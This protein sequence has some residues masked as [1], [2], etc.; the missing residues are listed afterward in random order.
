M[1]RKDPARQRSKTK[2]MDAKN[3]AN[4]NTPAIKSKKKR[5]RS[6]RKPRIIIDASSLDKNNTKSQLKGEP[7]NSSAK[8]KNMSGTLLTKRVSGDEK[9][10]LK[11]VKSQHIS[12]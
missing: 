1:H 2:L 10:I 11:P 12:R 6:A 4:R 9:S 3:L 5:V 8:I 7:T